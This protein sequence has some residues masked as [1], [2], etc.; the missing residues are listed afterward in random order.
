MSYIV[1]FFIGPAVPSINSKDHVRKGQ[2]LGTKPAFTF[3]VSWQ[4]NLVLPNCYTKIN[5]NSAV[6][7]RIGGGDCEF[8]TFKHSLPVFLRSLSQ[9]KGLCFV[10]IFHFLPGKAIH[11][12]AKGGA[13]YLTLHG[14]SMYCFNLEN[15]WTFCEIAQSI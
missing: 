13:A 4:S 11:L 10:W 9:L 7:D 15:R 2:L 14:I 5:M 12:S 6:S 1:V 3:F 8:Y